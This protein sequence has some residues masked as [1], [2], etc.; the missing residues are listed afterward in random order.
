LKLRESGVE[1]VRGDMRDRASLDVAMQG[2][3]AVFA[4]TFSEHDGTEVSL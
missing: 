4:A 1:V 2:V 3:Y